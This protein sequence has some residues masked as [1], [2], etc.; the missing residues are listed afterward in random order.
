MIKA[1]LMDFNGVIIDDELIQ[2]EAYREI[3][4]KDDIDLTPEDYYASLGM[5]DPTFVR[6]AFERKGKKIAEDRV[7]VLIEEKAAIWRQKTE[8]H[9]PLFPGIENFVKKMAAE[10]SLAI[11]SM[12]P[13]WEIELVLERGGIADCFSSIISADDV[14]KCKPDPECYRLGFK[15]LDNTRTALGHLPMTHEEC[16]VIEDSPAGILA[17]RGAG[18]PALGVTNTVDS[19]RLREAGAGAVAKYLND[20]NPESIRL[21]FA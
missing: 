18:L 5:D 11:C 19:A 12:A 10:F 6:A 4:K 20:W 17:A 1:I 2:M 8:K 9:L 13:R 14:T 15:E 3:L 16:L 21:V 7:P